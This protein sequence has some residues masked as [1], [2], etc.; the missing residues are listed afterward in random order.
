MFGCKSA[1]RLACDGGGMTKMATLQETRKRSA[2]A[3]LSEPVEEKVQDFF[4]KKGAFPR[5]KDCLEQIGMLKTWYEYEEAQ[6]LKELKQWCE[7]HDLDV[8]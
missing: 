4:Q 1:T 6:V 7:L 3:Y 8:E 5:F 2:A